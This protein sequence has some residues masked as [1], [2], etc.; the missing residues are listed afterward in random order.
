MQVSPLHTCTSLCM[1]CELRQPK[2]VD[3]RALAARRMLALHGTKKW[4]KLSVHSFFCRR[5]H[6][7]D[8]VMSVLSR[9]RNV[10]LRRT[11]A[12]CVS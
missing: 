4:V 10:S 1:S 3:I 11:I 5:V 9:S 7:H 8:I 12:V 6:N 2:R